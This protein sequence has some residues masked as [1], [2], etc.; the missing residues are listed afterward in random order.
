MDV[1][2]PRLLDIF[3]IPCWI[4]LWKQTKHKPQ[5]DVDA[6]KEALHIRP[7]HE[8]VMSRKT[9]QNH[10]CGVLLFHNMIWLVVQPL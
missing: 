10:Q 5:V 8:D 3:I 2:G 9:S 1:Q 6:S 4:H 7:H